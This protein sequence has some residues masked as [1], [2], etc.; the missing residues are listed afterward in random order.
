[1][2]EWLGTLLAFFA[3]LILLGASPAKSFADAPNCDYWEPFGRWYT[4]FGVS[5]AVDMTHQKEKFQAFR[6]NGIALLFSGVTVHLLK[7][8]TNVHRPYQR[9]EGRWNSS[10]P[11]GHSAVAFCQAASLG[12]LH[13]HFRPPLLGLAF[14]VGRSRIR[15]KHHRFIDVIVG[16][17]IGYLW[18]RYFARKELE[19]RR[20]STSSS[21]PLVKFRF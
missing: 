8:A 1:M 2:K 14:L 6:T 3:F 19:S 17:T 9:N 13:E 4:S 15:S 11:S 12:E 18:G 5:L 20:E 10:F 21:L 7:F 16:G